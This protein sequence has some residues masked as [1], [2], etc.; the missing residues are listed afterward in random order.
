MRVFAHQDIVW[1]WCAFA[2]VRVDDPDHAGFVD[3]HETGAKSDT[4]LFH[5]CLRVLLPRFLDSILSQRAAL[6]SALP[7]TDQ[8]QKSGQLTKNILPFGLCAEIDQS[9]AHRI[10]KQAVAAEID[11]KLWVPG[12][13]LQGALKP[14]K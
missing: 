13:E 7:P 9:T 10:L 5:F 6:G 4:T 12:T 8:Q 14:G 11:D 1:N 2:P 3:L